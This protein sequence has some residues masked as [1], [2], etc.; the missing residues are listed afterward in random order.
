M[1][2]LVKDVTEH[3]NPPLKRKGRKKMEYILLIIIIIKER[4]KAL[5]VSRWKSGCLRNNNGL[6]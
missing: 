5:K 2:G 3:E 6:R 1:N 4:F